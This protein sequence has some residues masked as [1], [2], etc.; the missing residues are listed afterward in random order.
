MQWRRDPRGTGIL[1]ALSST[2]LGCAVLLLVV[3]FGFLFQSDG[4]HSSNPMGLG[5]VIGDGAPVSLAA[6]GWV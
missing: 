6:R 1:Y 5:I 3:A 4:Q 2:F